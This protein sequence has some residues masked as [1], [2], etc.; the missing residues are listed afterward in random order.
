[1]NRGEHDGSIPV[2]LGLACQLFRMAIIAN[3]VVAGNSL[4]AVVTPPLY[5]FAL[6][7]GGYA[8]VPDVYEIFDQASP[9]V[10]TIPF[11]EFL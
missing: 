4:A 2:E 7:K 5:F 8:F 10:G 3:A 11:I 6:Q 1:M 9:V